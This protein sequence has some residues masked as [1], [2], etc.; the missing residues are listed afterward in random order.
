MNIRSDA[1]SAS[2]VQGIGNWKYFQMNLED[3][4]MAAERWRKCIGPVENLWLV[5]HVS[6]SWTFLQQRLIQE[7][8]WTP[9]VGRDPRAGHPPVCEGSIYIDFNRELGLERLYMHFPLE[10]AFLFIERRLAFWHSDLLCRIPVMKDLSRTFASLAD[11]EMAAV[12]SKVAR[13]HLLF[14]WRHRF[15]ELVGCTTKGAS[16]D[17][18]KNGAGWWMNFQRHPN[19]GGYM[20]GLRRKYFYWDHG[21]GVFYWW[22]F[23]GGQ[24]VRIKHATVAEGHCTSSGKPDY[25]FSAGGGPNKNLSVELDDN[26]RIRTVADKLDIGHLL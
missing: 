2:V 4:F 20:E 9:L 26:Y 19:A 1:P 23:Y 10:F 18:L 5:W 12:Y 16:H 6:D 14:P 8:G 7:V 22:L 17:Q 25:R 13:R 3:V 15:F 21:A 11:R 24:V